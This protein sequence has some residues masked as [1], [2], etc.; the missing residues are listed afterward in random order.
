MSPGG[1]GATLN[2]E[3][4]IQSDRMAA[5]VI[6]GIQRWLCFAVLGLVFPFLIVSATKLNGILINWHWHLLDFGGI[7]IFPKYLQLCETFE[8][9]SLQIGTGGLQMAPKHAP[10][11]SWKNQFLPIGFWWDFYFMNILNMK[12]TLTSHI[13]TLL[14][15]C[16]QNALNSYCFLL[17]AFVSLLGCL[18]TFF[19]L[20][21]TKGKTLLEIC[22]EFKAITVCGKS[23]TEEKREETK[24]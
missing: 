21:E 14:I 20:P 10:N 5:F 12:L 9:V 4:F 16:P 6:V 19:L 18:Y 3:L 2:N 17:F 7:S 11:T 22:E 23:F 8:K 13:F 24:L 1:A 15:L